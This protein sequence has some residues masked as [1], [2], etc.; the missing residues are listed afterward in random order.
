MEPRFRPQQSKGRGRKTLVLPELPA[1]DHG[2][3]GSISDRV[4]TRPRGRPGKESSRG[5]LSA[6]SD[7][8][9]LRADSPG[10]ERL[11]GAAQDA[12]PRRGG[13]VLLSGPADQGARPSAEGQRLR[14]MLM[15]Y[16]AGEHAD[17]AAVALG[18]INGGS[19]LPGKGVHVHTC[20]RD[21][22][23]TC[24]GELGEHRGKS[25]KNDFCSACLRVQPLRGRRSGSAFSFLGGFAPQREMPLPPAKRSRPGSGPCS[26][27]RSA[28]SP[29]ACQRARRRTRAGYSLSSCRRSGS[30]SCPCQRRCRR[31]RS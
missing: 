25:G 3:R 21:Q 6:Q 20:Q 15:P 24:H 18:R 9:L 5:E 1:R 30:S 7:R 16:G 4:R 19:G 28:S 8:G 22:K 31:S 26:D 17:A 14:M 10:T 12:G 11:A 13:E 23:A 27:Q 2:T 29:D